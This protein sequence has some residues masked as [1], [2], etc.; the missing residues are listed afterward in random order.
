MG[1]IVYGKE[2]YSLIGEKIR[3]NDER[4]KMI[5]AECEI[6]EIIFEFPNSL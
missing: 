3:H 2:S 6:G 4:S 5:E 1:Q